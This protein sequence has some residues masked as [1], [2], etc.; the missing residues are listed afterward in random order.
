MAAVEAPADVSLGDL[1]LLPE[2]VEDVC[3]QLVQLEQ[4]GGRH[5]EQDAPAIYADLV[6]VVRGEPQAA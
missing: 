6:A 4:A 5:V 1:S 2:Q 3:R